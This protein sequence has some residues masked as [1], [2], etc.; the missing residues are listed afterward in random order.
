MGES[1][2]RRAR[3]SR[4]EW[5]RLIDEQAESGQT[6]AAFCAERGISVTSLQNWKRRLARSESTGEPWLELGT[7]VEA[8][9]PTWDIELDL[10][11]GIRLR[12]RRC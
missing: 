5:Q 6:Q 3:R 11:D 10:G 7:L 9:S 1:R 8:K 12:L 2:K 4:D